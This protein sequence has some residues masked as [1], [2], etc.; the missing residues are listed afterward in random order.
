VLVA[1]IEPR[2]GSL[3][4]ASAGHPPPLAVGTGSVRSLD[5]P[6][7]P[8]LGIDPAQFPEESLVIEDQTL[9]LFTDGLIERRHRHPDEGMRLLSR[10]AAAASQGDPEAIV[11]H[12]LSELVGHDQEPDDDVAMLAVRRER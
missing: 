7:G 11:N 2:S 9:I 5:V 12:V 3:R 10:A 4:L 6:P 1:I 8:P